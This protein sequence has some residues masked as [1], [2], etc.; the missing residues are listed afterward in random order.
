MTGKRRYRA[1]TY[2]KKDAAETRLA[3]WI[4]EIERGIV[5][6]AAKMT[7]GEY[8]KYWLD[9]YVKYNTRTT[10]YRG[11]EVCVRVHLIPTLGAIPLRK[12]TAA[13]LQALLPAGNSPG[14]GEWSGRYAVASHGSADA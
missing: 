3:E 1:E 5:V 14:T 6:D 12:L 8:L 11:Y 13:H 4:T 10:T 7:V 2:T 9:T